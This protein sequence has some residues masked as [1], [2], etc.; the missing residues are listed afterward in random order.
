MSFRRNTNQGHEAGSDR[1]VVGEFVAG[2]ES[3]P[4]NPYAR[5]FEELGQSLDRGVVPWRS[6]YLWKRPQNLLGGQPYRGINAFTRSMDPYESPYYLTPAKVSY[7]AEA[8]GFDLKP[9]A[10]EHAHPVYFW[11]HPDMRSKVGAVARNDLVST[12]DQVMDVAAKLHSWA[13]T[14]GVMDAFGRSVD[15]PSSKIYL[16]GCNWA[17]RLRGPMGRLSGDVLMEMAGE[18]G[19]W[20]VTLREDGAPQK[21]TWYETHRPIPLGPT[22]VDFPAGEV[23]VLRV[24]ERAI[25]H[26]QDAP[27]IAVES[28]SG[29]REKMLFQ[30]YMVYNVEQLEGWDPLKLPGS[31]AGK[32]QTGHVRPSEAEGIKAA[33]AIFATMPQRPAVE[34]GQAAF[35]SIAA[36]TVTMPPVGRFNNAVGYWQV[37]FH[38]L[39][40]ATGHPDRLSRESLVKNPGF[41]RA[42]EVYTREELVAEMTSAFIMGEAG[43]FESTKSLNAAYI[44]GWR[45]TLAKW[46]QDPRSQRELVIAAAQAQRAA[47]FIRGMSQEVEDAPF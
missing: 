34:D 26:G 21:V 18:P 35:Y 7:L 24:F 8:Y 44:D 9:K 31:I 47:D 30:F 28:T 6:E 38:E 33:E 22:A 15:D 1:P 45:R 17:G 40:H 5:V 16:N 42:N 13:K 20:H 11:L 3:A 32:L 23:D 46:G 10:G 37:M 14:N 4:S 12:D 25:G 2:G 36:D 27:R 29:A 41:H 19:Q 43:L 39:G